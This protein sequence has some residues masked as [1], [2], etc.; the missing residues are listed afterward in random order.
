MIEHHILE[1]M[2][3]QQDCCGNFRSYTVFPELKVETDILLELVLQAF[4]VCYV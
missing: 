2:N 3:S 4:G 1:D